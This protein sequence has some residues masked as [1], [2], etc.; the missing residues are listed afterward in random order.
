MNIKTKKVCAMTTI[1]RKIRIPS[2]DVKELIGGQAIPADIIISSW[3]GL[4]GNT[5][6]VEVILS[7]KSIGALG[8]FA[9]YINREQ[10]FVNP[11]N[12]NTS[13]LLPTQDLKQIILKWARNIHSSFLGGLNMNTIELVINNIHTQANLQYQ[14]LYDY[15][16]IPRNDMRVQIVSKFAEENY[17]AVA[18]FEHCVYQF[19]FI[20]TNNRIFINMINAESIRKNFIAF[21]SD[22]IIT[23]L[24]NLYMNTKKISETIL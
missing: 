14:E 23:K 13:S 11:W 16:S 17:K 8:I 12:I 24:L 21:A 9:D 3:A 19:L 4:I 2:T 5:C 15:F 1:A 6:S 7:M 22:Q 18:P 20:S 10:N